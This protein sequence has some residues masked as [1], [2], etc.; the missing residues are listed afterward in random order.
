MP[1]LFFLF[2]YFILGPT[3]GSFE[4][5]GGVS[6]KVKSFGVRSKVGCPL[7]SLPTRSLAP[8]RPVVT[9]S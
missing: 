4:E 7:T 5:F 9:L 2:H 6:L 1:Q 8:I 3:F